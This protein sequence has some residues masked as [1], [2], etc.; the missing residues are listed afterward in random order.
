MS[1][2]ALLC[3][4]TDIQEELRRSAAL[5]ELNEVI[6]TVY[7]DAPWSAATRAVSMTSQWTEAPSQIQDLLERSCLRVGLGMSRNQQKLEPDWGYK[8]LEQA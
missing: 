4:L 8:S 2:L 5:M 7:Y 1:S 6:W 3:L